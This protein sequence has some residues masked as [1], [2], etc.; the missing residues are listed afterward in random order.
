MI[1]VLVAWSSPN[2]SN[3][4]GPDPW[5]QAEKQSEREMET[6]WADFSSASFSNFS[7]AF[8]DG[9]PREEIETEEKKREDH[10]RDKGNN[11]IETLAQQAVDVKKEDVKTVGE[12]AAESVS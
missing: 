7:A 9:K 8:S 3:V 2:K 1:A 11:S 5:N 6:G 4:C 12:N 10:E